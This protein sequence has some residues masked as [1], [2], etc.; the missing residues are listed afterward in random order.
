MN[1]GRG[2]RKGNEDNEEIGKKR[3]RRGRGKVGTGEKE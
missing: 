3:R 1:R 2:G